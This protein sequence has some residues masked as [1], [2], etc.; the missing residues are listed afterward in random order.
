MD[1]LSCGSVPSMNWVKQDLEQSWKN[2]FQHLQFMFTG[3]LKDKNEEEKCSFLML[4]VGEKGR[5][6]FQTWNLNDENK[7]KTTELL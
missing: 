1:L 2:F 4:W 5:S 6:I 3:P 7:K